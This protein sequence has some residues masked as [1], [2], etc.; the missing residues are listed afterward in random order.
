M[1]QKPNDSPINS[2]PDPPMN[3]ANGQINPEW[4]KYQ[5]AVDPPSAYVNDNQ[6]HPL[7]ASIRS[8]IP[9]LAHA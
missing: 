5:I 4:A 9:T 8:A 1:A 3:L 7:P 2:I 6:A